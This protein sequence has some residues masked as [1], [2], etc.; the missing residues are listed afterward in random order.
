MR[1]ACSAWC[2]HEG[3]VLRLMHAGAWPCCCDCGRAQG[4][5][6]VCAHEAQGVRGGGCSAYARRQR[7]ARP[8][9]EPRN[10][11]QALGFRV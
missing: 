4:Q 10:K 2:T 11:A 7:R 6:D 8:H 3:R 5:P 1:G 9:V